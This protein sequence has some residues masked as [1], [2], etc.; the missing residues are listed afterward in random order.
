MSDVKIE[1]ILGFDKVRKIISDRCSTEYGAA[2][3][4]AEDFCTDEKE[5]RRPM[6]CDL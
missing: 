6:K 1:K 4:A 5:I 2:R 3:A